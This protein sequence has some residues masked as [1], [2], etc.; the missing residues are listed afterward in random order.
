MDNKKR[1]SPFF[2]ETTTN[3]FVMKKTLLFVAIA[4]AFGLTSCDKTKNCSCTTTQAWDVDDM[5]PMVSTYSGTI[6][7]GECSD[8]NAT[9][10]SNMGGQ[11]YTA[12]TE[13]VEVK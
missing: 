2:K 11:T 13:C 10:R 8:M 3:T 4:L 6:E 12:K 7:K 1:F 5:E 9:Q